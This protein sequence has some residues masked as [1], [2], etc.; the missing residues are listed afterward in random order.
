MHDPLHP[1]LPGVCVHDMPY[2]L[3]RYVYKLGAPTSV[4][5]LQSEDTLTYLNKGE[6]HIV[7]P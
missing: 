2:P 5:Q 4:I 3:Y 1:S 7:A 6:K